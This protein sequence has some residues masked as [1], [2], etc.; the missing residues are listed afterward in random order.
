MFYCEQC[1]IGQDWPV[2]NR[3]IQH[4]CLACGQR[5][6]C[7][8]AIVPFVMFRTSGVFHNATA[9]Q[10]RRQAGLVPQDGNVAIYDR[11]ALDDPVE[12]AIF[13]AMD[14]DL[15]LSIQLELPPYRTFITGYGSNRRHAVRHIQDDGYVVAQCGRGFPDLEQDP[16][17]EAARP[18]QP[19][20]C[21]N[22]QRRIRASEITEF[23]ALDTQLR[24]DPSL[25]KSI[26]T[27]KREKPKPLKPPPKTAW[28]RM[29]DDD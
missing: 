8:D 5:A 1:R 14:S 17:L 9:K 21:I 6:Q 23:D 11:S 19:V 15:N 12:G 2:G 29:L 4:R 22:C 18:G 16:D 7:H 3:V 20:T 26:S 10:Y 24:T 27:K 25:R 13:S 28:E